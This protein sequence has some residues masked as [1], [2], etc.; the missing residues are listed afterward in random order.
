MHRLAIAAKIGDKIISML[1]SIVILAMLFYT[2][3]S[4][5]DIYKVSHSGLSGNELIQYKP[6]LSDEEDNQLGFNDLL[7]INEDV[8]GWI[9][10]NDTDIDHPVVQGKDDFEYVNKNALGEFSMGGAIYLSSLN[11]RDLSDEYNVIY[12]HNINGDKM[13]AGLMNYGDKKYFSEHR[14]GTLFTPERKFN[15]RVISCMYVSAY[16]RDIYGIGTIT[17]DRVI[18]Y[19]R[20]NAEIFEEP[21]K[22]NNIVVLSTCVSASSDNRFIVCCEIW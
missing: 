3:Y 16:N 11:N 10:L 12:G 22:D 1:F 19:L 9:T 18:N 14:T 13:F 5:W 2:G 8:C 15:I 4:L 17:R 20:N 6:I 7:K 21:D